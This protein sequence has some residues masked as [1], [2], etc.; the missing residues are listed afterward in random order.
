M[1]NLLLIGQVLISMALLNVWIL[2][3]NQP[4]PWRGGDARTMQEEFQIYGLPPWFMGTIGLLKI[5]LA[6]T[7]LAG[8][9]LP[10]FT[11]VSSAGIAT[12]MSGAVVMHVKAGDPIRKS[13]PALSL[14]ALSVF[15][16]LG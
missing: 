3:R 8:L 1:D 6:L 16:G 12:L 14:L 9:W 2:R 15:V 13:A 4:T 11:T 10:G 5:S 7:L